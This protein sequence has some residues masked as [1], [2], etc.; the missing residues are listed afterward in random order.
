MTKN[1]AKVYSAELEGINAKLIEVELDLN[2]GLH[3][4]NIVGL[5]DKALN[6]AKE[7]V[8]AA[9]KNSGIKPPNRENRKITVNLAPADIKKNGSHYDLAI[10]IGYLL[11][12]EQMKPFE[13]RDKLF[14]GE[15]ALDGRL[16]PVNG[17]LNIAQMAA[18]LGF[19]Y[20]FLPAQNANEAAAIQ[21]IKIIPLEKLT[22]A[23][24][25]LEERTFINPITFKPI[26]A[27]SFFGPDFSEI[28]GQENAKRALTIAAAGSH[29]VLLIGPPGVGKSLLAQAL[30]GILPDLEQEEA[31]EITKIWSAAG[32]S[33]G[34][35]IHERPFRAPHQTA[36]LIAMVGGGQ[37]PKPGE[38]SLAHRG[39]LFLDE[40]PEFQKTA[41][42]A[43]RQ[44]ME[45]GYIHVSRAKHALIFPAKFTLIAA[46]NPCPC[47]YYGDP[48]QDC[49]CAPFEVGKYQKKISGPLLDRIDLQIK[50]G[51]I[52]IAELRNRKEIRPQSPEIKSRIEESRRIQFERFKH[53]PRGRRIAT[54]AE[55]SSRQVE[56]LAHPDASAE[57]FLE[58]I[59]KP[60]LSPRGYYRLL[61]VARTI[62]DL[63]GQE[64]ITKNHIAEAYGYRIKKED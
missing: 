57:A 11:A 50:V 10:A 4:F 6:E 43:L 31:I 24:D 33:P 21:G 30:A 39:V 9:L 46:M 40:V 16:R 49:K 27:R 32:L 47:G 34:G 37:N 26:Q 59:D 35:L 23:I 5:A 64:S 13:T 29:N 45:S 20:F 8:N 61:K 19:E 38:I 62:A 53:L 51:R 2:V 17:A 55:M 60:D 14:L 58:T 36:S 18:D 52:N 28:K 1:P 3:S 48:E 15:L 22:D 63:E 7:R 54:N 44:P 25:F 42:E 41:L 56:N 12:T